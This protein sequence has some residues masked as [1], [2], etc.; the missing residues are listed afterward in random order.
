[1]KFAQVRSYA[2]S[3]PEA[4]EEPHFDL[5]SF[6]VR[7]KIFVTAPPGEEYIHVFVDD[8]QR[9]QALALYPE[10]VEKLMWGKKIAGVRVA[11]AAAAP[12]V[13]RQLISNAWERKAPKSLLNR[14]RPS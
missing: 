9:E 5:T 3:L 11:L 1:M 2:L 10:F 13:V 12:A 4:T 8:A 14:R 7:G 6:R